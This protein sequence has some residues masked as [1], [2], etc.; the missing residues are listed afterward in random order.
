MKISKLENEKATGKLNLDHLKRKNYAELTA[1]RVTE[2]TNP[3]PGK[4]IPPPTLLDEKKQLTEIKKKPMPQFGAVIDVV[5]KSMREEE[6]KTKVKKG[7]ASPSNSPSNK[8][9]TL[10][11]A[12]IQF[13]NSKSKGNLLPAPAIASIGLAPSLQSNKNMNSNMYSGLGDNGNSSS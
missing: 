1:K 9:N 4:K 11:L 13:P 8:V 2:S 5:P 7:K 12:P 3:S 10:E 6:Q